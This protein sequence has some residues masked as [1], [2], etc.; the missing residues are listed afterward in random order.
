M[1]LKI[2]G[3][4]RRWDGSVHNHFQNNVHSLLHA[5]HPI[6]E[7]RSS[8]IPSACSHH[9]PEHSDSE[10]EDH[11]LDTGER[12]IGPSGHREKRERELA[13]IRK[14]SRKWW[15]LTGLPGRPNL[16]HG[17]EEFTVDWT[18]GIMPKTEGRIQMVQS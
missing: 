5:S 17:V 16:A 2:V 13:I 9:E 12:V 14:V 11:F 7:P 15:R 10:D 18:R 6:Q 8:P 1:S 3:Q 4:W